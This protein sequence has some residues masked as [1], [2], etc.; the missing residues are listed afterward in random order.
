MSELPVPGKRYAGDAIAVTFE[1]Q[2]CIHAAECVR[3]LPAVFERNRRPWI[4]PDAAA[5]AEVAAVIERC[6]TGALHYERRDSG[7]AGT[8]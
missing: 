4:L 1:A 8:S 3:R 7:P 5:A 6:P 2:R